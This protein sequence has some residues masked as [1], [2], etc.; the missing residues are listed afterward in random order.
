[1]TLTV[2]SFVAE[3][4]PWIENRLQELSSLRS[5]DPRVQLLQSEYQSIEP[6]ENSKDHLDILHRIRQIAEDL[7]ESGIV[8]WANISKY[9]KLKDADLIEQ[10]YEL[11]IQNVLAARE[12]H[13]ADT[14][15]F[16]ES[17]L[18]LIELMQSR[19][20]WGYQ[21][22]II[23][24]CEYLLSKSPPNSNYGYCVADSLISTQIIIGKYEDA[25]SSLEKYRAWLKR[26]P[27]EDKTYILSWELD[28][29]EGKWADLLEKVSDAYNDDYVAAFRAYALAQ[30]GK[31]EEAKRTIEAIKDFDVVRN[32]SLLSSYY[33]LIGDI[34]QAIRIYTD[35]NRVR[36]E[37]FTWRSAKEAQRL[38]LL[39][40]LKGDSEQAQVWLEKLRKACKSMKRALHPDYARFIE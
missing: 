15:L 16:S 35:D 20:P 31:H 36:G 37:R 33:E 6:F 10:A 1:M 30:L 9:H 32:K 12:K 11:A 18:A 2:D 13:L 24:A 34:D 23:D 29:Y 26:N 4:R 17:H 3:L 7:G 25:R 21:V 38:V 22:E 8:L 14:P 5:N 27:F 28:C 39:Y 19:D 40:N